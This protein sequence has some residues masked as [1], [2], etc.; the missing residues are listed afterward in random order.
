MATFNKFT[1]F[2][3]EVGLKSHNLNTET[4][5]AALTNMAPSAGQT[6]FDPVTNHPP[7]AAAN[8]YT[9]GGHDT[10]NAW[11]AGKLTGTDIV[12][13]ATAGGIGPFRYVVLYNDDNAT[14]M[15]VG[16]YDYGSS[17]T[18]AS[19]ETFTIDFDGTNGILTIT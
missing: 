6:V 15:L 11:S 12:I 4:I 17:I 19:G 2:A 16:W 7:P 13:T 8:G 9:A 5:K 18:L 3:T 10:Q 1:S 14:D